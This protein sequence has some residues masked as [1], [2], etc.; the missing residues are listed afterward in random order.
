[1]TQ[2]S[3]SQ[4]LASISFDLSPYEELY[5]HFHAN[6]ELSHLEEQTA[7]T[8]ASCLRNLGVFDIHTRIGGHGVAAVF[9]N[10]EGQTVLLRADMD[11]LPVKEQT[12]LPY[13]STKRM[14]DINGQEQSVMHACGHDMHIA[15]LLA[16]KLK[17]S[18]GYHVYVMNDSNVAG[19]ILVRLEAQW[20]GTLILVFQPEEERGTGAQAMVDGG[21]YDKVPVPDF[22]LGQHVMSGK[23]GTVGSKV[24]TIMAAADSYKITLFGRGGHGSMPHMA[25]D[26]VLM[27]SNLIVRLQNIVS[28]EVDPSDMAVVT[29]GS[30]HIGQAENIISD[31][32]EIG[33]DIRS[34]RKATRTK[35]I[36]SIERMVKAEF[37]ASGA[38]KEPTIVRTRTYPATENDKSLAEK[39]ASSFE[40]YF[41]NAFN[42]DTPRVNASEDVSILASSQGK[43]Y[44][45][46]FWG[47]TDDALWD[48]N[49]RAE[50]LYENVPGNHS[51]F[52]APVI[53][54]TLKT[55]VDAMCVAALTFLRK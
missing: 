2:L 37:I 36:S 26:P 21:L 4:L 10:G 45:F 52:F 30:L 1:M 13:A 55:G 46:W 44:V 24:G 25:I 14:L 53:Q 7:A 11:A 9:K 28:R 23:A 40:T 34:I 22:V 48:E 19:D 8:I 16:G 31:H 12:G 50:T 39:L 47:G 20:R 3:I 35:I 33:I 6:P 51:P 27:A 42:N 43:P 15:C 38:T 5:R 41:G 32:A 17:Q 29:V 49:E 54:P 18:F